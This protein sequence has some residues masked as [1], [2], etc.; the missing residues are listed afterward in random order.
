MRRPCST[1]FAPRG[2]MLSAMH[3]AAILLRTAIVALVV[4]FAIVR[5]IA[6]NATDDSVSDIVRPW[7]IQV[8][9]AAVL[10]Y[11]LILGIGRLS[12]SA[13]ST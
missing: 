5:F 4:V 11:L 12:R 10:G 3:R 8:G 7:V 2:F 1:G 6:L 9:A 13:S